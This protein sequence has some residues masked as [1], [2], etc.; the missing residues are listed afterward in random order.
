MVKKLGMEVGSC[1]P[2]VASLG[3]LLLVATHHNTANALSS[4]VAYTS[5]MPGINKTQIS[6]SPE[7]HIVNEV[8][9]LAP[10][11]KI[12]LRV[13]LEPT[14]IPSL[15]V[16]VEPGTEIVLNIFQGNRDETKFPNPCVMDVKRLNARSSLTFSPG[17]HLCL[18]SGLVRHFMAA[19]MI[20]LWKYYPH[21]QASTRPDALQW[22]NDKSFCGLEKLWVIPGYLENPE[23]RRQIMGLC[24]DGFNC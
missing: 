12:L 18:G 13:V 2:E 22:K 8:L 20:G 19:F 14:Y 17:P 5:L 15:G 3:L 21:M 7:I 6:D 16:T 9:R 10:P 24:K 23:T 11:A 1:C 4:I